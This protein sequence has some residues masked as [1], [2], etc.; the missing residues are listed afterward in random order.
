LVAALK[1]EATAAC[2]KRNRKNM[3][4]VRRRSIRSMLQEDDSESKEE[5]Y[6]SRAP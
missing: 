3:G 4:K 6:E 5:D 2:Q 1:N